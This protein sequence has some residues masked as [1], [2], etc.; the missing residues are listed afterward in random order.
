LGALA[1]LALTSTSTSVP[2]HT[3]AWL[4]DSTS[5]E[6]I[7]YVNP[8]DQTLSIGNSGLLEIHLQGIAT[9]QASDFVHE[10]TT[11]PVVVAG[12]SID[13]ALAATA[14]S[15]GIA[16]ATTNAADASSLATVSDSARLADGN[17]TLHT[18][19]RHI[20]LDAGRDGFDLPGHAGFAF[21]EGRSGAIEHSNDEA[22]I[23]LANRQSIEPS[24]VH[25]MGTAANSFVFDQVP[26]PIAQGAPGY[27]GWTAGFHS[28]W[29]SNSATRSIDIW[30]NEDN[31]FPKGGQLNN[32][33]LAPAN[34]GLIKAAGSHGHTIDA[35]P[36]VTQIPG[37]LEA[38]GNHG[39]TIASSIAGSRGPWSDGGHQTNLDEANGHGVAT[40]GGAGAPH[41][42]TTSIADVVFG[43]QAAGTHGLGDSFHFKDEI[44]GLRSADVVDAADAGFNLASISHRE[45]VAGTSGAHAPWGE[46]HAIELTPLGQHGADNFTI[47]PNQA[48]GGTVVTHVPHDLIV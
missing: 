27:D 20:S 46:I 34:A 15:D 26:Q 19:D 12:E 21:G 2:A 4:Y 6:T 40:M 38:S 17:S 41:F 47:A 13:L 1:F 10:P 14:G 48:E 32:D 35:G 31:S 8:T 23:T 16:N 25:V 30:N 24:S 39:L 3:I 45:N 29:S 18:A 9:I 44:S 37:V 28:H 22:V 33:Q 5:N 43:P 42:E 11:A 7:V 36:N